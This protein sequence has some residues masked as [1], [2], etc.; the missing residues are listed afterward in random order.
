MPSTVEFCEKFYGTRDIYKIFSVNKDAPET[1][2]R[3]AY[4]KLSLIV[5]PDRVQES[6]KEEATEKFKVLSRI[7]AILADK[8]K[9]AVYDEHGIIDDDDDSIGT[10]WLQMWQ[11]FFKPI[12]AQDIN[13]YEKKYV[14]S[15]TER[16]DIKKSYL[17]GKGCI[18]YLLDHVQF[19][20]C[21]DEPR[22]L[23]I[24]KEMIADGE[25]PEYTICTKEPSAKRD[26]RHKRYAREA[27]EAKAMMAAEKKKKSQVSLEQQ[28][29][30][31]Q[32][33]R[34]S[35][36]ASLLE[37]YSHMD[38]EE[39]SISFEEL[40]ASMKPKKTKSNKSPSKPATE[41]KGHKVLKGRVSKKTD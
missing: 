34:A 27:L 22:I 40:V 11:H 35:N 39:N 28:I 14:G 21:K 25:I 38:D 12:S 2:I 30:L 20:N 18:N 41:P 32:S 9:R 1:E 36:F 29:A 15:E 6:E 37:K 3:K 24:I 26:R 17:N 33:Q 23:G 5:H 4:Y 13:D 8:N 16:N 19:M 31:Q 7:Y 10:N